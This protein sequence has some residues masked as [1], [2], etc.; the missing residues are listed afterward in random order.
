MEREG[1]SK[2]GR[3]RNGRDKKERERGGRRDPPIEISGYA[4][5]GGAKAENGKHKIDGHENARHVSS[6]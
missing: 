3:G 2:K 4:T 5:G 1:R 6:G